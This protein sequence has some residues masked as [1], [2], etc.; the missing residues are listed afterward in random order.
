MSGQV[1]TASSVSH[2]A[3][4]EIIAT[5]TGVRLSC[6]MAAMIGLFGAFL[7]WAEKDSHVIR[8]FAVQSTALTVVHALLG[9]VLLLCGTL[10][11]QL[12]YFGLLT[13]LIC[14]LT[15]I[16]ILLLLL[17][18]RIRLMEN[19]WHGRRHTLPMLEKLLRRYY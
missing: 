6:T 11:G 12:P 4:Q 17:Y 1:H 2:T 8:R 16:S 7:C 5:N 10:L 19:A 15:Y 3:D 18:Q 9:I 13:S 14:W